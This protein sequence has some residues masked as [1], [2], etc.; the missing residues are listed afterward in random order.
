ML[1]LIFYMFID[2]CRGYKKITTAST[3]CFDCK[4]N[5]FFILFLILIITSNLSF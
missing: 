4:C 2:I 5:M 3:T 1:A